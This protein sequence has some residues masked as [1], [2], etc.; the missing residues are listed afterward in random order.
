MQYQPSLTELINL[1]GLLS[2]KGFKGE[3]IAQTNPS[4]SLNHV[5]SS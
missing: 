5:K 4:S 2:R 3:F 1:Y